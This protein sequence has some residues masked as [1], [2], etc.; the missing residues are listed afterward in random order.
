MELQLIPEQTALEVSWQPPADAP[1]NI[2][3]YNI[4]HRL[5]NHLACEETSGEMGEETGMTVTTVAFSNTHARISE[6]S[7]FSKYIVSVIALTS[8]G[9]GEAV[10]LSQSTQQDGM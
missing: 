2:L 7:P 10:E 3:G 1:C 4:S 8:A 6:L 5:D 9:A